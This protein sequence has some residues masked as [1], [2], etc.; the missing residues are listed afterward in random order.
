MLLEKLRVLKF[1][2]FTNIH[3]SIGVSNKRF[4]RPHSIDKT[5]VNSKP[6]FS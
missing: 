4:Q 1:E 5:K 6:Y 2:Q 3:N